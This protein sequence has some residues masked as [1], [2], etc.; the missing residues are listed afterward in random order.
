MAKTDAVTGVSLRAAKAPINGADYYFEPASDEQEDVDIA[1]FVEFNITQAVSAPF[2][3]TMAKI[4]KNFQHGTSL[5]EYVWNQQNWRPTRKGANSKQYTMLK[6]MAY[7]PTITIQDIDTDANGG[8]VQ[9]KQS[10]LDEKGRA[11]NVVIPIEKAIIFPFGDSDNLF[12]D[13]LLRSAYPHWYYKNYFYKI[14]GIQKERHGIGIPLG[15]LPPGYTTAD[16]DA[17]KS[18]VAN[19]RTNEKAEAVIPQGYEIKF[20]KPEGNLVDVLRSASHHDTLILLNVMAEFMILGLEASGSGGGR[21]TG[22]AQLDIFYKSLWN[23]ANSICAAFNMYLIPKLVQYNF[24]TDQYPQM[25][26]RTIGQTRD[27]QQLAAALANVTDKE[28][29]VPDLDTENWVRDIF[30]MPRRTTDRPEF[31]PTQIREIINQSIQ[32]TPGQVDLQNPN[33]PTTTNGKSGIKTGNR[34]ISGNKGGGN[35]GA[36]TNPN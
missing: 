35:F 11:S 18:L 13:S 15:I 7:R 31:S 1:E 8:P 33:V 12:G 36:G 3:Y 21:A 25:K 17:L 22:A 5:F 9:I 19:I 20:M 4:N 28:L 16:K 34:S 24:A 27:L 2:L 26:V 30:D 23:I 32:T 14:D 6:K 29:V 10:A